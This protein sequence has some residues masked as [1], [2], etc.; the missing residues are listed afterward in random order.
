MIWIDA[1]SFLELKIEG[2]PR[3]L[4]GKPRNVEIYFR[5]YR[6]VE[7]VMIPFTIETAVVGAKQTH[8]M[9]LEKVYLNPKLDDSAFARPSP[10]PG[11]PAK[12]LPISAGTSQ[13]GRAGVGKI[14]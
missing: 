9:S 2:V 14:Q 3:I 13:P 6:P 12:E 8:R 7:G 11:K 4:D 10:L 1:Q 5:D